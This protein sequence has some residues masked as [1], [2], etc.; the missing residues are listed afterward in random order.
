MST[1]E[2]NLLHSKVSTSFSLRYIFDAS[3]GSCDMSREV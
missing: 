2:P 1:M 3:D